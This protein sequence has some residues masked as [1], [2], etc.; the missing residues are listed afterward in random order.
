M[1]ECPPFIY[2][3]I[4]NMYTQLE[5]N[6]VNTGTVGGGGCPPGSPEVTMQPSDTLGRELD[7]RK[8]DFSH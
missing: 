1:K 6:S 7:P 3:I 2:S 5:K 8:R 4:F